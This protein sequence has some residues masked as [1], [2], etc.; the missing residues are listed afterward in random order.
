VRKGAEE[1]IATKICPY[2]EFIQGLYFLPNQK[3]LI[4]KKKFII[5]SILFSR[6]FEVS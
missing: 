2:C 3:Y 1:K 6:K 5:H 4:L